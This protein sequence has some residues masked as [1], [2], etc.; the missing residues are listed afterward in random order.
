MS[1][2]WGWCL[3]NELRLTH[4]C[5]DQGLHMCVGQVLAHVCVQLRDVAHVCG[6]ELVCTHA[7][8]HVCGSGLALQ[9]CGE[10]AAGLHS[11]PFA[12]PTHEVLGMGMTPTHPPPPP[13]ITGFF[14]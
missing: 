8:T 1:A 14:R 13:P 10:G 5:V 4:T 2:G 3:L 11:P 7:H 12:L 6:S 9:L